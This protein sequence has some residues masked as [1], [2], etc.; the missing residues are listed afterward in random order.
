MSTE[1]KS[2]LMDQFETNLELQ[3]RGVTTDKTIKFSP[4]KSILKLQV[5][6][7]IKLTETGFLLLFEAIDIAVVPLY[8]TYLNLI[9]VR[10]PRDA[11]QP[12]GVMT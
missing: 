7:E 4:A 5:G 12:R 11:C 2:V 6:D 3:N 1:L 10:F 9:L 8:L